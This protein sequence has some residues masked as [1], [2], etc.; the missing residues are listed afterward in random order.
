MENKVLKTFFSKLCFFNCFMF[1]FNVFSNKIRE[2]NIRMLL[3][4]SLHFFMQSLF[5]ILI[6]NPYQ[7][8]FCHSFIVKCNVS[9]VKIPRTKIFTAF[10]TTVVKRFTIITNRK[11]FTFFGLWKTTFRKKIFW[12]LCFFNFLIV[13]FNALNNK[14]PETKYFH[15]SN[16]S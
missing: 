13:E 11:L 2:K 9:F 7:I 12:K 1:D 8:V 16:G 10:P 15:L 14:I 5:S 3:A 4:Q 6:P